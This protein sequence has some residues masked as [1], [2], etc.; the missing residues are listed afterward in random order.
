[1]KKL[2]HLILIMY[3][4]GML[5][6]MGCDDI[7]E[8]SNPEYAYLKGTWIDQESDVMRF[9]EFYSENQAYFGTYSKNLARYDSLNYRITES[10]Q[11]VFSSIG[12]DASDELFHDLIKFGEDSI[13]ISNLTIIPEN[14]NKTYLRR[15]IITEKQND[16]II[17]GY[18]QVYYDFENDFRLQFDSILNDSRCPIGAL[19]YWEGNAEVAL[20]II[21][22][23]CNHYSPILNTYRGFT[24]DTLIEQLNFRLVGL[25]PC[26][27]ID[28]TTNKEDY[29]VKIW[30]DNP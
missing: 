17:I 1:M 18:H 20:T 13:E 14:P 5:P 24:T 6:Y 29:I 7:N 23:G 2:D 11:I 28:E 9:I 22:G 4:I 3:L 26:P 19:C 27:S 16:T 25:W 15:E 30:V 12:S 21:V 8:V 10:D